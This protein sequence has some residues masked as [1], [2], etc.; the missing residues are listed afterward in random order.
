M[1]FNLLVYK[2]FS[3]STIFGTLGDE[4]LFSNTYGNSLSLHYYNV[5]PL[6]YYKILVVF[7]C[8][9]SRSS[10]ILIGLESHLVAIGTIIH[11]SFNTFSM[12][13]LCRNPVYGIS[14]NLRK[15]IPFLPYYCTPV[16]QA[17]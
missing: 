8:M 17:R 7:M 6:Y 5:L 15:L 9:F 16:R 1:P 3:I 13:H 10:S 14:H 2:L 12:L 4:E 11:I